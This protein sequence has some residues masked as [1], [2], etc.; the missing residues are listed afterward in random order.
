[1]EAPVLLVLTFT[2]EL[3]RPAVTQK[4]SIQTKQYTTAKQ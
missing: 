2:D 1:M 3:Q 4:N